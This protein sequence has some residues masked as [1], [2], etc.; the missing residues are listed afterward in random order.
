MKTFHCLTALFLSSLLFVSTNAQDPPTE[1]PSTE[2][3]AD[4]APAKG[5]PI[6]PEAILEKLNIKTQTGKIQ[7]P[8][9]LAELNLPEDL[10]YL[11]PQQTKLVV[12]DLW[13]NP[14]GDTYLGMIVKDAKDVLAQNG[15]S[16]IITYDNSGYI[17]DKDAAA[18][19]YTDMLKQMQ[20]AEGEANQQRQAQGFQAIHLVGWAEAPRYDAASNKLYWAKELAFAGDPDHTL[21][22]CIR[23]LGRQG[24]LE[25]NFVSG[26]EQLPKVKELA[27]KVLTAVTFTSGNKY[28]DFNPSTDRVAGYGIA[29][30]VAGGVAAK[31]GLFK[32]LIAALIAGKKFVIIG[33]IA[34]IAFLGKL[35]SWRKKS[36]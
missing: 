31:A 26:I 32:V 34:V 14:P 15:V 30:L 1:Q 21:N 27:P 13:G 7:L 16:A 36:A 8:G 22:Y 29:A 25:L 24:V 33:V 6:N 35:F 23:A 18:I 28:A 19:N 10:G 11:D 20:A 4:E 9:G 5:D 12:E 17:S 3:L 2:Q